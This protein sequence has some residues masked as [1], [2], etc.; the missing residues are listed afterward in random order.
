MTLL[1]QIQSLV[2]EHRW[3]A[4]GQTALVAVSG[5]CDSM[6]LLDL[7]RQVSAEQ[8]FA[9]EVVTVDHGLR[10]FQAERQMLQ[11]YCQP[12]A[13]H[14]VSLRPGLATRAKELGSSPEEQARNERYAALTEVAQQ[15]GAVAVFLAHHADDQAETLLLNLLR[16]SGPT[17]LAGMAWTR[18]SLFARPLLEVRRS[19]LREWAERHAVPFVED[20][21]NSTDCYKRNRVRSALVPALEAVEPAAVTLLCRTARLARRDEEVKNG[22]VEGWLAQMQVTHLE[23]AGL[24]AGPLASCPAPDW[25]LRRELARI[26]GHAPSEA[27]L[28]RVL[29][30]L[31]GGGGRSVPLGGRFWAVRDGDLLLI[32]APGQ[33][34]VWL[35]QRRSH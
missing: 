9:L 15:R 5:G 8:G 28:E 7:L 32:L 20:P 23:Y 31:H 35:A 6:V 33:R 21:T 24:R 27:T 14:M 10:S 12:L 3:V 4:A 11:S 30:L 18:D 29:G 26:M 25:V 19:Q 13:L 22:L 17:G 34:K 2:S 16:G 1:Q